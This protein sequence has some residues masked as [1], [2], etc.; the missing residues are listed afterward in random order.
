MK[1]RCLKMACTP[2]FTSVRHHTM[3]STDL[4]EN[5]NMN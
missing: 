4:K 2:A 5:N 3:I 1:S